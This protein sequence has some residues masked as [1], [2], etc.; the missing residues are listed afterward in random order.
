[1]HLNALNNLLIIVHKCVFQL[2]FNFEVR[3]REVFPR[4]I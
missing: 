1:M 4:Y 3:A 2:I